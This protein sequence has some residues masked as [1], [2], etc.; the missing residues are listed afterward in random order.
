LRQFYPREDGAPSLETEFRIAYDDHNLYL[1]IRAFDPHPDSIVRPLTRRD[2]SSPSDVIG[3]T[4]DGYHDRRTGFEFVINPAGV[5][6]DCA[7]YADTLYDW[8]WDGVWD[9]AA[10]TDSAGWTAE[11]R[12][13]LSQ[14]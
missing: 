2:A 7:V 4:I 6:K 10:R 9:A 13:P 12:I 11:F 14:F 5:K 3:I 8:S 1:F